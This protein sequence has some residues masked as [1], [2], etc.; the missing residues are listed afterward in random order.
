[1]KKGA[2]ALYGNILGGE[3]LFRKILTEGGSTA[4]KRGIFF[5]SREYLFGEEGVYLGESWEKKA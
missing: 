1:M 5:I 4:K 2:P 3:S